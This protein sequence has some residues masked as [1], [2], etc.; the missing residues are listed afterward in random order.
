MNNPILSPSTVASRYRGVQVNTSSPAQIVVMLFDGILRFVGEADEAFGRD[1][2]ARAGDRI[3]RAMAIVDE[4][5]ASLRPEHAPQVADDL[6][7][8]YGFCKR[9]LYEANLERKRQ[10]LADVVVAITPLREAFAEIAQSTK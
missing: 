7:A 5:A 10:A 8:L 3:G 4:L 1:D 2:R 6:L 9:R